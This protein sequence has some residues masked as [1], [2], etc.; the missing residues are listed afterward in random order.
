MP[1]LASIAPTGRH[2]ISLGGHKTINYD[3]TQRGLLTVRL[4]RSKSNKGSFLWR[5]TALTLSHPGMTTRR[6]MLLVAALSNHPGRDLAHLV[7]VVL[8]FSQSRTQRVPSPSHIASLG[9][10][11]R[12]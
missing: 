12:T 3:D 7:F 8:V 1:S 5:S 11:P 6:L 4:M 10:L 2:R 9:T